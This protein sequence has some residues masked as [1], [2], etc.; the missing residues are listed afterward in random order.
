MTTANKNG[1]DDEDDKD[2]GEEAGEESKGWLQLRRSRAGNVVHVG[3]SCDGLA[4]IN[5][6]NPQHASTES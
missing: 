6:P 2:S 3:H 1:K 5:H 4:A